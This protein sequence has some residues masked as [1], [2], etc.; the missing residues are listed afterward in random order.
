[1]PVHWIDVSDLS[2]LT[3]LL[4]EQVQL[5]WFPGW[6]P[7]DRLAIA[8]KANPAV[9]WYLRHKCPQLND[10]LDRVMLSVQTVADPKIVRQAEIDVLA[11][12]ND[13]VVY[14][15]DPAVYDAQTF[16]GWDSNELLGLTN[17]SGKTVADIGAGAGRLAL[18]VAGMATTVFA[19]EPV[20]NLRLYLK[21]KSLEQG[22]R[23]VYPVDGLITEIA[24]QDRFTDITMSGHIFG[25][26]PEAEYKELA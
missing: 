6:L 11:S 5:S 26:F 9:E 15:I 17:F 7:E 13:L 2:F 4:L 8:L 3:L 24:F 19:V 14:A 12:I 23:N 22:L 1:M 21:K 18:S 10:W 20:A 25:D 16:L